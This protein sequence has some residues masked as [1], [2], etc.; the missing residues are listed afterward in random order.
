MAPM[1]TPPT[2]ERPER[3]QSR[4]QD[5]APGG[6]GSG[7]DHAHQHAENEI[8]K[9]LPKPSTK[10]VVIMIVIFALLLAALFIL[11]WVPHRHRIALAESDAAAVADEVPI[12][13][14]Q[15]PKVTSGSK[16]LYFPGDVRANQAT[17]IYTRAS[18]YLRKWTADIQ[19]HVKANQLLAVIEAPE[20][21]AELEQAKA[22]LEQAKTNVTK[23][24]SDLKLADVTL[25]RYLEA[26]KSSPGSVTQTAIDQQQATYDDAVSA[27]A[28]SKAAVVS[29]Q[30]AVQQLTVTQGFDQVLAPFDG[31]ITA[32]NYDNGALLSPSNTGPGKE[33]FDIAQ[34]DVLR[35]F[36]SVPQGDATAV[37]VGKPGYL[38]V[39]SNYPGKWFPGTVARTSDSLDQTT[40]TLTVEVDFPNKDDALRPGM[41]GQ[42]RLPIGDA[43]SV[44]MVPTGALIFNADGLQLALVQDDKIHMQKIGVGRDM[45]TEIEVTSGLSANDQVVTNPGEKIVE[46]VTV[47]SVA[48][49]TTKP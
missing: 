44:L 29:G 38:Q 10:T 2:L 33:M 4:P 30:A 15:K 32:R 18:G 46:G 5:S 1:Q 8:P 24:E 37:Q 12:V 13:S 20:I 35:V 11:G 22:N 21:D 28:Q 23:A 34:T 19:D 47:K 3:S 45:G 43:R 26:Q 49:P 48:E 31:V 36:V 40:R 39:L 41:F 6:N 16:D 17:A 14:V 42:I 27:L 25:K 9:D 7:D